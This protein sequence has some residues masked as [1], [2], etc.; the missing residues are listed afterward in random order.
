MVSGQSHPRVRAL[1][2]RWSGRDLRSHWVAVV[3]IAL[4]LAIGSGVWAGLGSTATWRRETNDASF[5]AVSMHDLRATLSPGTFTDAGTL[6][7]AAAGIE[8]AEWIEGAVERLVVDTQVDATTPAEKVLVAGRIV[9]MPFDADPPVDSVWIRDGSAPGSG[10]EPGAAGSGVVLEA[11]F[12]DFYDLPVQGTLSLAGGQD[13]GYG[14]LGVAPEDFYVTG[15]EGTIFAQG[16]L[17]ILYVPLADA[18]RVAGQPGRVNDLVLTL[19]GGADRDLVERELTEAKDD[20]EGVTATVTNQ[21][22]AEAYRV[23]YEDIENDQQIWNA[24][25]ALVLFA[26]ALAASNLIGR[27]VEAQRREIGIGMALGVDRW[28]LA[29][30]PLLV[31]IQIGILGVITGLGVGYLIG[32][33]MGDLLES[34]LPLPEYRTP[35]QYGVYAQAAALALIVPSVAAA[36]PGWRAVRVEPIE[37]IRTGHLAAKTSR[38]TDW[39][40]RISLPGSTL[41]Q[42]PL[43]NVLRTPRRTVLTAVGVGAAI[44]ALVAVLGM[45]D[46]FTNTIDQGSAELTRGDPDRVI[47]QLDTFYPT[48]ADVVAELAA[49]PSVAS[50]DTGLRLPATAPGPVPDDDI[51]LLI[52]LIDFDTATWTPSVSGAG[53]GTTVTEGVLLARKAADDLG[54]GVGEAVLLRHPVRGPDGGFSFA[55]SEFTVVGIHGNPIRNFVY[56]DLDQTGRFGLAGLTNMVHSYPTQDAER[57]DLQYDIFELDGVT[58]SQAVARVSEVFDEA[59]EQF[60]GFL[61]IAAVAVLILALL[62]AFNATRI[63][64]EERQREH[65]TMR[66]YGLPVRSV[67]GVVIKESVLV[68]I[69]ATFIGVAAGTVFLGWMLQSLA[70]RTL[71]DLGIDLYLAPSTIAIA[72]I[73]GVVAVSLAPLFLIRRLRKMSIPD[74]LR[75]ME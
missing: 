67:M 8:H 43:R 21:D 11:K 69:G 36:I 19:V 74:T 24:I 41:T 65:A 30:R 27:I 48:D 33:A 70:A 62:I 9:G 57:G 15:P 50:I 68:G 10:G 66:A 56:A 34:F 60:V 44:T 75:V 39:S 20:L 58:S 1:W 49:T 26:A 18:Q 73:V 28:Q 12:A 55:E 31:G 63:T 35:F 45:L 53:D 23:L 32:N 22:D 17:A 6:T 7:A 72:L 5:A 16:E 3:A 2:L 71:P 52:E 25:S 37:A 29:I 38:L 14:G 54:V 47:V 40:N 51:E 42:M 13:L 4:V 59:L 64:V 46:S 61:V